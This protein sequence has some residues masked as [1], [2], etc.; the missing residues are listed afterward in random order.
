[1]EIK[2]PEWLEIRADGQ[3][4]YGLNQMWYSSHWKRTAGCGPT[5]AAML[6]LYLNRRDSGSLGYGGATIEAAAQAMED[7]WRFITPGLMGLNSTGKFVHGMAKLS[8][9]HGTPWICRELKVEKGGSPEE[10]AAFVAQGL[11]SDCPVAFLNLHAGAVTAFES[12]HWIVITALDSGENHHRATAYDGG[13]KIQ[14]DLDQWV[15]TTKM[16]G[17]F[18]YLEK[19]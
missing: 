12:W 3:V 4:L 7:V 6:L 18:V 10:A 15:S 5:A 19:P 2:H 9:H 16:G 8:Q 13:R 11:A 14:F 1:M 17:G